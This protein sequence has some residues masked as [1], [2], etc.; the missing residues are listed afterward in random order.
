MGRPKAEL[1][2]LVVSD[3]TI[4]RLNRTYRGHDT[5]TDVLAFP[6]GHHPYPGSQELLGDVVISVETA[7]KQARAEGHPLRTELATLLIHG[8]LHLIGY[9][10]TTPSARRRMWRRQNALLRQFR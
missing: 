8:I 10:D 5:P 2:V 1:S 7:L 4:R 9:D 6:Q 3:R